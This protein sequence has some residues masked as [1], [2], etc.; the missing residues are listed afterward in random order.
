[1]KTG[2]SK[3]C[4]NP[5]LGVPIHGY[6]E[7]RRV[8]GIHDDIFAKAVAFDDGR[9]R[10]VIIAVDVCLLSSTQCDY[11]R[12]RIAESANVE[13]AGVYINCSHTHTG[14]TI[15][16]DKISRLEGN[17]EYDKAFEEAL[18]RA[19]KEAFLDMKKSSFSYAEGKAEGI[20]FVRRFR[21][22][23]GSVRTN[24]GVDNPEID[25]PL[26]EPNETL[27]LVR[28]D[29]EGGETLVFVNYGL[30]SD[31]VG[32]EYISGD[33]PSVAC[34]TV[35]QVIDNSQCIF[36]LG[37]EGDVAHVNT[38]PTQGQRR[39]LEYDTFDGVPRGYEHTQHIG[40]KIAGVAIGI[41]GKA[42]PFEA[43]EISFSSKTIF[44]PS[45]QDNSKLEEAKRIKALYEAGRAHELPYEDMELTTVVA[46]AVRVCELADGPDGFEF[47]LSALKLGD[48]ALAGLPGECFTQ[49]GK[50]IE[51]GYD[52]G[53]IM[54]CCITN[55]GDSYFPTSSAYDE[56]GYEARTSRLKKGGDNI[57]VDGVLELLGTV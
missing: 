52:G 48:F 32:G 30:H 10:A 56:G 19:A 37:S 14:P 54:V 6:Y 50:R 33:W 36:L 21:M 13:K 4:I 47:T 28:I 8:K 53:H 25:C 43:D 35:E 2:F 24:P 23:D 55:G 15:G 22:K 16:Y 18:C 20:A 5:P 26:G 42:E 39:G 12:E 46:E 31:T 34:E 11:F 44:I 40:R 9:K 3:V 51:A 45:N 49:I 17:D 29:R 41:L 27:K 7:K 38:K 57:I 1:M